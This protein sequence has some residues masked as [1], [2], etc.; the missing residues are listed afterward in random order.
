MTL[1]RII[2]DIEAGTRRFD[3]DGDIVSIRDGYP[4]TVRIHGGSGGVRLS[5]AWMQFV[6]DINVGEGYKYHYTN[7]DRTEFKDSV[8]WHN[9]GYPNLIEQL[10]FAG[11][12][13]DVTSIEN[14]RAYIR[15]FYNDQKPPAPI[16]PDKDHLDPLVQLFTTQFKTKLDMTTNGKYPRT[17][18]IA[19]SG[20]R[21]WMD[22]ADLKQVILPENEVDMTYQI[23]LDAWEGSGDIDEPTL[24]DNNCAGIISRI[25]SMAGG[26]HL[27]DDFLRQWEQ[28]GAFQLRSIYFVYNPWVNGLV[29]W[30]W[31]QSQIPKDCPP[32]IFIDVEVAY[33]NYPTSTYAKEVDYFLTKCVQAGYKP[34]IY[35]GYGYLKLLNPWPKF[36]Y[37]WARY[38][39]AA[40]PSSMV[41]R[42]EDLKAKLETIRFTDADLFGTSHVSPGPVKL[43][44]VSG[45]KWVLPG[46]AGHAMDIS[47]YPGTLDELKVWWGVAT[48]PIPIPTDYTDAE[49]L[50]LLWDDHPLLHKKA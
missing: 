7:T 10:T 34:C 22:I 27:D 33:T 43:W 1:Y 15:T 3:L 36:D 44:Q 46:C 32:R 50:Q 48:L 24:V 37:W 9:K 42:W 25:N 41:H 12:I 19:N 23:I 31:L 40:Q 30:Q 6:R 29:N 28:N 17:V 21:L 11:N 20:E 13:V 14:G 49:K 2:D 8:G 45:D 16:W 38:P 47:I 4:S 35:T 39:N 18:I 26:H 5:D